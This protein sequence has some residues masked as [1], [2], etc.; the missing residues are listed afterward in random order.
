VFDLSFSELLLIGIVAVVVV[1]PRRLPALLRNA[2]HIIGRVRRMALDLRAESGIDDILEA[3]GIRTEIDNFRRLAAGQIS[4]EDLS[5]NVVPE[6]EREYPRIGC[7]SYGAAS[8]DL[9]PY[10]PPTAESTANLLPPPAPAN[11]T[12]A[13][14]SVPAT[15]ATPAPAPFAEGGQTQ[16]ELPAAPVAPG[17]LPAPA[18]NG[19]KAKT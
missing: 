14:A 10:L 6:R 2:G 3:E 4:L 11:G 17:P 9:A 12:I 19:A 8:E 15:V 5:P 16:G 13:E 1:G 7:D 18:S